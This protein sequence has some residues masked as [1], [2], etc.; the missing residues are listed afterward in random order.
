MSLIVKI[1][2]AEDTADSDTRKGFL[3]HSGVRFACFERIGTGEND[4]PRT[5]TRPW[6]TLHFLEPTAE[7]LSFEPQGNVY[8]M[9][10]AGKTVASYGVAPI[11]YADETASPPADADP[12]GR[13]GPLVDRFLSW[14]LPKSFNPDGGITF[15]AARVHPNHWP[16]GT[17][18][19]DYTQAE[20]MLRHV[21]GD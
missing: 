21:L 17:N 20:A 16:T 6:L 11:V 3:L 19:L 5:F 1:M 9:N 8:V 18:L 10:E 4:D 14:Q 7:S 15:D 2:S 12:R 13:F